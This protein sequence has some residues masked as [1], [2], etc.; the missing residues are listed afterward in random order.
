MDLQLLI[1]TTV[2]VIVGLIALTEIVLVGW[3]LARREH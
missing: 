2:S 1:M 3:A